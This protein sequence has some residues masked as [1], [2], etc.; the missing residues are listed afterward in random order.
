MNQW[1]TLIIAMRVT[2]GCEIV[3][4]YFTGTIL[5]HVAHSSNKVK[6]KKDF[7]DGYMQGCTQCEQ[8]SHFTWL[9]TTIFWK[10]SFDECLKTTQP[11]CDVPVRL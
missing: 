4:K 5:Q 7:C 9:C 10:K 6:N 11:I 2:F 8:R 3:Q 1:V